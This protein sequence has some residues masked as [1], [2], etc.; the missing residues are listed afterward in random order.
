MAAEWQAR[1]DPRPSNQSFENFACKNPDQDLMSEEDLPLPGTPR[2][3]SETE[4]IIDGK[5]VR[6]VSM[7]V[8]PCGDRCSKPVGTNIVKI[9]EANYRNNLDLCM[10]II[11]SAL[12]S[13][14]AGFYTV[15]YHTKPVPCVMDFRVGGKRFGLRVKPLDKETIN[16][17]K[18]RACLRIEI[19]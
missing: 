11:V 10:R 5:I 8:Y 18:Q 9:S 19:E 13:L 7:D 2:Y 12:L 15:V 6:I 16:S 4:S 17:I 1:L 14:P 3:S